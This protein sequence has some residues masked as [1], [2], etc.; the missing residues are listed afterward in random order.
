MNRFFNI[1]ITYHFQKLIS[2][3]THKADYVEKGYLQG[4]FGAIPFPHNIAAFL[5]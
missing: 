5:E 4:R 3:K 1:K 2:I